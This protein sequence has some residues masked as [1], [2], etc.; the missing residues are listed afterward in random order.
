MI[1]FNN[2]MTY[3]SS[4]STSLSSP[5]E[6]TVM[7]VSAKRQPVKTTGLE[8]FMAKMA[9]MKKVLSPISETAMTEQ[10][11][12]NDSRNLPE[13]WCRT[14]ENISEVSELFAT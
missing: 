4:P 2:I 14:G 9:A 13:E 11:E 5:P 3:Y 12:M 1:V 10:E 6:S 8:N 7:S